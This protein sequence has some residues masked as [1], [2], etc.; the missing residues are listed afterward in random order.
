MDSPFPAFN[1]VAPLNADTTLYPASARVS[2]NNHLIKM[3][4]ST[5]ASLYIYY[6]ANEQETPASWARLNLEL[7]E[8]S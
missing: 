8:E 5:T 3:L 6:L 4:D 2:Y 1:T 7:G